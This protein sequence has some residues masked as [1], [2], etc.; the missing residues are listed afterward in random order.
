MKNTTKIL[1][2]IVIFAVIAFITLNFIY[3]KNHVST[4]KG[5]I[6]SVNSDS[7]NSEVS[8]SLAMDSAINNQ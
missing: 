1:I 2:G 7:L 4:S 8:D 6:D 5:K 3:N